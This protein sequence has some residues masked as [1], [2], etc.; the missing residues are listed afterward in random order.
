MPAD[1]CFKG[2]N[3][4]TGIFKRPVDGK[5]AV[6]LLHLNGDGQ[7]DLKVHG[8]R[9]KAVYV[10]PACHYET[11]ERELGVE[12]LEAAQFGENLTVGGLT[13]KRVTIGDRYRVGSAVVTVTQPRIPCFKLGIRMNDASFPNRFLASGRLGFY[14]RVLETGELQTGDTFELLDRPEH[15][16][17]V[18]DLW[19]IVFVDGGS[20]EAAQIALEMLPHIDEGWQKRLRRITQ[21]QTDKI[22]ANQ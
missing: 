5:V 2:K 18:H 11:W 3:H 17:S 12:S 4:T 6:N 8:G 7:A 20:S 13:E 15:G 1:V 19:Q 22:S 14:M 21:Q 16:I 10:Y 9:D